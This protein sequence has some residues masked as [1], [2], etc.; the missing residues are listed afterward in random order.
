MITHVILDVDGT[1]TDGGIIYN[2]NGEEI[3]QTKKFSVKDGLILKALPKLGITTIILTGRESQATSRR[4][5]E[6][7]IS[8]VLQNI[9]NKREELQKLAK[10]QNIN[11]SQAAYIGDDLNDYAAMQLC[12]FKACPADSAVEVRE[13]CDYVS[14]KNGG[15]GAVRDICE[16]IWR[17]NEQ[18][19]Q[20]LALFT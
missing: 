6:L 18:Y 13:I 4:A 11:L 19:S 20:F 7:D 15:F 16:E 1:L 12:G 2:E 9:P 17:R 5:A 10:R 8:L 3:S 14:T